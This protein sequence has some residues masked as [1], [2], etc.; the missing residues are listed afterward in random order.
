MAQKQ[1]LKSS[2]CSL[3][4]CLVVDV[5]MTQIARDWKSLGLFGQ[6]NLYGV[7]PCD[8]FST[9]TSG[10]QT[11][12]VLAQGSSG[13]CSVRESHTKAMMTA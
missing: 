7:S 2:E 12:Y 13:S 6:R 11:F 10:N 4:T 1:R 9:E 5:G 8:F 3:T